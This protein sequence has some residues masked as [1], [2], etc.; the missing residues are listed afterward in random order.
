MAPSS[1]LIELLA[2]RVPLVGVEL[3][4][5]AETPILVTLFEAITMAVPETAPKP[6]S[7]VDPA[8]KVLVPPLKFKAAFSWVKSISPPLESVKSPVL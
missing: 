2:V 3:A 7:R 6:I 8:S 1:K 4:P 5:F